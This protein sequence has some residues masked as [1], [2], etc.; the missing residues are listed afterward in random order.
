MGRWQDTSGNHK[1]SWVKQMDPEEWL[2]TFHVLNSCVSQPRKE[3]H[4]ECARQRYG[5]AAIRG[6]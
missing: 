4:V 6:E 1:V 5:I 3:V 2:G